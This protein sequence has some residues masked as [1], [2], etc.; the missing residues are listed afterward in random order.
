[1]LEDRLTAINHLIGVVKVYTVVG[2]REGVEIIVLYS[3][4][5]KFI[6]ECQRALHVHVVV[7]NTMHHEEAYVARES[8]HVTDG[9]IVETALI[10]LWSMHI[11]L[12]I[13]RV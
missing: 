7:G 10:M 8:S 5:I 2:I 11:S 4:K 6:E 13:N 1:M 3:R 12:G 9:G